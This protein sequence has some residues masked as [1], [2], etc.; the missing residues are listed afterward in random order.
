MANLLT[1]TDAGRAAL[2]APNKDGT[3]AHKIV[4]I[5]LATA[6]F[7]SS[8]ALKS[9]PNELKRIITFGG[10]NVAPDTIHA[11]LTDDSED[12]YSLYGFGLYLEDGTLL[13]AYGQDTPIMEKSPA[14][15]LLLSCDMQ[16]A[17]IDATQLVFGET[18]F[19]NPPATTERQ[20]V[21]ELATSA[22][23]V[24]GTDTR[25][26]ATPA[27]V[28]AA[29]GHA[30][31]DKSNRGHHHAILEIDGLQAALDGKYSTT[32]GPVG[33]DV[34][35]KS[36]GSP[37][38]PALLFDANGFS[39][40]VRSNATQRQ[41]EF[42]N[43]AN[44][45]I[46]AT[47]SD[48]GVLSLPRA[49]PTWAGVTPWDTGNLPNPLTTNGGS[50]NGPLY[51]NQRVQG[52]DL[53]SLG[54]V[55]AGGGHASLASDGNLSGGV[56]GGWLSNWLNTQFAARDN[57]INARAPIR[58]GNGG[59]G[60]VVSDTA[61]KVTLNWGA[62]VDMYVDTTYIGAI[63]THTNFG[64]WAAPRTILDPGGVGS[65]CL[66]TSRPG[67]ISPTQ[68]SDGGFAAY[69]G[70]WRRQDQCKVGGNH[71]LYVYLWQRIS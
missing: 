13:A 67:Y 30:I 21:V 58:N 40:F 64:N 29:I 25:R 53:V 28:Q 51:S 37:Y 6:A 52:A 68:P 18:S 5:G 19:L 39:P 71:S 47:L 15:L 63:L 17:A 49:R 60:Y 16:F 35:L 2:V 9:L 32:G 1:L 38:S 65:F 27:G 66:R 57:G 7:E 59:Y 34:R 36:A 8:K 24:A 43:S 22:E 50:I 33:G 70:N 45:A 46:N 3:N 11:T 69:S 14:A 61:H 48:S 56:W 12:Q 20:G 54:Y 23:T 26:A 10:T 31:V 55:Y 44:R 62:N 42:V 4:E 41:L